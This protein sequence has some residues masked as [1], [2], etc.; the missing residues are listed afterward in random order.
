[1]GPAPDDPPRLVT[2]SAAYGAGGSVVGPR[3]A[4][5]LGLPFVDR[6]IPVAVAQLLHIP[7]DEAATHEQLPQ[8]TLGRW[9]TH[10]SPAVQMFAGAPVTGEAAQPTDDSFRLATEAVLRRYAATGGVILGRAAAAFLSDVAGAL[11]VRLDGPRTRRIELAARR[12]GLD[13]ASAAREQRVA[14]LAR[15]TYVRHWYG[16]DPRDPSLYHLVID[17]TV[18]GPEACVELVARA[19]ALRR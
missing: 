2:L 8:G 11:H 10:F 13:E 16:V 17:S 6:A 3:L 7:A 15:E 19:V 14:D 18:L 9:I 12:Q 1:M 4:Q 5:R